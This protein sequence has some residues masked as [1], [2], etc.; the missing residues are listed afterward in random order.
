LAGLG[1][2][3]GLAG[4]QN[5]FS[6]QQ[7]QQQLQQLGLGLNTPAFANIGLPGTQTPGILGPLA[8][9]ALGAAGAAGGFGALFAGI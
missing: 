4:A 1:F 9:S 5:Q 3:G 2:A 7:N 6:Q 8:G